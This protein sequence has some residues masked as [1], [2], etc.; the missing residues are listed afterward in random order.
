[1]YDFHNDVNTYFNYQYQHSRDYIVPLTKSFLNFDRKLRVLEIG[2]AEA[3]V[4][5]AFTELGHECVG[6]EISNSRVDNAKNL[7]E[8][9]IKE[10]LVR[11]FASDIFKISVE[12][13]GGKFDLIV[14]KDVI[15]H[16][17]GREK[18]YDKFKELLSLDGVVFIAMP[19]WRMPFGGHQ[20]MLHNKIYSR[21]PYFHLLPMWFTKLLLKWDKYPHIDAWEDI[22]QTRITINGFKKEIKNNGFEIIHSIFYLINPNYKFKF[23]L[24]PRKQ[25]KI[26][27]SIPYLRDFFTTTVYFIIKQK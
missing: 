17:H 5:K 18:L 13:L 10:G 25:N 23:N 8:K 6:V 14:L 22:R 2:S 20:Q 1:M 21:M 19:P 4:L 27:A 3:G 9:E 26:I 11:F 12:E 24:K 7:M 16:I 15:E